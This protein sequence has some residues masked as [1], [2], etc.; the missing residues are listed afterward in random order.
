MHTVIDADVICKLVQFFISKIPLPDTYF[1]SQDC[2][3]MLNDKSEE[4]I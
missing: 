4:M 3:Q 2:A 1:T